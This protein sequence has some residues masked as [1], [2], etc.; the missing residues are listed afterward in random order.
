MLIVQFSELQLE[1][2]PEKG[3]ACQTRELDTGTG[4]SS[5]TS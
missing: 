5:S 3:A 1:M 2:P 4:E